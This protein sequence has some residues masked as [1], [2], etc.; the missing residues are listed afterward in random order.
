MGCSRNALAEA[1]PFP[2][3]DRRL[4]GVHQSVIAREPTTA[5]RLMHF[6]PGLQQPVEKFEV[7][8]RV[9]AKPVDARRDDHV[10]LPG[11]DC[12]HQSVKRRSSRPCA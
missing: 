10:H 4:D 9:A 3:C 1:L 12:C 7:M 5:N 11:I 6:D 8:A 2:L